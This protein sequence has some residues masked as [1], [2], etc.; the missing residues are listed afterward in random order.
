MES[1]KRKKKKEKDIKW[2]PDHDL[3]VTIMIVVAVGSVMVLKAC[4]G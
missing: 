3:H 1:K 2:F 4:N